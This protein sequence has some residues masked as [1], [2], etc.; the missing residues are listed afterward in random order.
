MKAKVLSFF[1][2]IACL[3]LVSGCAKNPA[4]PDGRYDADDETITLGKPAGD[5][6]GDLKIYDGPSTANDDCLLWNLCTNGG[7]TAIFDADGSLLLLSEVGNPD[8]ITDIDGFV[9]YYRDGNTLIDANCGGGDCDPEVFSVVGKKI[10]K[11]GNVLYEYKQ[12]QL[13][14]GKAKDDQVLVTAT[15]PIARASTFRKL[16]IALLVDGD[17]GFNGPASS[18]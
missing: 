2:L 8:V 12:D 6:D 10:K 18:Q 13:F 16:V 7:T 14:R 1:A 9:L 5:P 4:M 11:D 17:F 15:E 3:A